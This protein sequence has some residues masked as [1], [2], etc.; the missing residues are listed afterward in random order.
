MEYT[1]DG[2]TFQTL[3]VTLSSYEYFYAERKALVAMDAH[4]EYDVLGNGKSIFSIISARLAGESVF[5]TRF[6]NRT[7]STSGIV[8][9]G[10]ANSIQQVKLD[11]SQPFIM[12]RGSYLAS[13]SR[14][15]ICLHFSLNKMLKGTE[16]AFQS[17]RGNGTLFFTTVDRP[18]RITLQCGQEIVVDENR[19]KALHGI[20]DSRINLQRK[21]NVFRNMLAG[22]GLFLTRITGPGTVYLSAVA[23]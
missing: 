23:P 14:M 5:L 12:R 16:P 9:A 21:C 20:P 4:T 1:I 15:K 6:Y 11:E 2:N 3:H 17:V 7:S 18:V 10:K 8:L 13:D 19:L 22:E